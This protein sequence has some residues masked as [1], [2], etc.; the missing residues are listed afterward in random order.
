MPGSTAKY[1]LQYPL[2]N[3][4]LTTGP[5]TFQNLATRLDLLRGEVGSTSLNVTSAGASAS[6]AVAFSRTYSAPPRVFLQMTGAPSGFTWVTPFP[7]A[8]TVSGFTLAVRAA[9][10]G[11]H[12]IDWLVY[13]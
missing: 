2:A 13:P 3:D 7:G 10:V 1:G 6:V 4:T 5:G 8:I 12:V 11:I 9:V